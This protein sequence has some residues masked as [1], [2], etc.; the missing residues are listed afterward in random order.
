MQLEY[1]SEERIVQRIQDNQVYVVVGTI[2]GIAVIAL[3]ISIFWGL[4]SA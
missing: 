3:A 4:Q 2:G 1:L